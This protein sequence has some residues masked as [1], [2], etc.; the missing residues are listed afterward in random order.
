[1]LEYGFPYLK[2]GFS[3]WKYIPKFISSLHTDNNVIAQRAVELSVNSL[4]KLSGS[5]AHEIRNPL[6]ALNHASQLLE[7]SPQIRLPEMRLINIIQNHAKRMN[8]IIETSVT[9]GIALL[10]AMVGAAI[11]LLWNRMRNREFPRINAVHLLREINRANEDRCVG[12]APTNKS[13]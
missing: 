11:A 12:S 13:R 9:D 7:E 3:V 6:A 4:A 5:I 2:K 10:G 1:M 8:G